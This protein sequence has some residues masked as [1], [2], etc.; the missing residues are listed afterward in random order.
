MRA[1]A[2]ARPVGLLAVRLYHDRRFGA[3]EPRRPGVPAG[4]EHAIRVAA[5]TRARTRYSPRARVGYQLMFPGLLA[6]ALP[7]TR[8]AQ[9]VKGL[10]NK[11][12]PDECDQ[13]TSLAEAEIPARGR[14]SGLRPRSA[15]V[16]GRQIAAGLPATVQRRNPAQ[17]TGCR[18]RRRPA[19]EHEA[20][21]HADLLVVG[22]SDRTD[23]HPDN[24]PYAPAGPGDHF[25]GACLERAVRASALART[26]SGS[27]GS[28][29]SSSSHGRPLR[30]LRR[31]MP[32]RFITDLPKAI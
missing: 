9:T 29:G 18:C 2:H 24:Q 26:M 14:R 31:P 15:R 20:F 7:S 11:L 21:P 27:R 1:C 10:I 4:S 19:G 5:A 13:V 3:R 8:R 16:L 23:H 6:G 25:P 30:T 28:G 32:I 17:L 22:R 12:T